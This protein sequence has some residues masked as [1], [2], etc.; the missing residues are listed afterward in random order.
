MAQAGIHAITGL[1]VCRW[2][3]GR[4]RL[5]LGIVLGSLL[6]DADN[7][8]VAVATVAKLPTAGLHRTFT[9][10]LFTVATVI[11]VFHMVAIISRGSRWR[12]L[13]LGLG[14]GIFLHILLDLIIWFNG[15]AVLWPISPWINFWSNITPPAWFEKLMYPGE[16]LFMG[17]FFAWLAGTARKQGTDQEYSPII[18]FWAWVQL[19]LFMVFALLVYTMQNSFMIIYGLVYLFSLGLAI[20]VTICMRETLEG[21]RLA[22]EVA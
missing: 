7:L 1:A 17:L 5:V 14:I 19:A 18:R 16:F 22:S 4:T 11:I 3:P 10:S 20:Y 13:G 6:P 15:V 8:A 12:N 9:H 21:I 2:V